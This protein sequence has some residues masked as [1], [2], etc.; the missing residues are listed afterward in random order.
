MD[1]TTQAIGERLQDLIKVIRLLKHQ[2]AADRPLVPAGLVG[3][4][5][6]IDKMSAGC[7]ARELAIHS[8]LDPSTVSRAVAG[9]VADGLVA[10]EPDPHDGRAS[11]LVVTDKG[12]AALAEAMEWY[13]SRIGQALADWTPDEIATFSRGLDR[14]THALGS[15]S[16]SPSTTSHSTTSHRTTEA[17][18]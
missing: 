3:L 4:L 15:A 11:V 12:H 10:R 6:L 14:F 8:S 5:G 16:T 2:R 7:H 13:G 9:L 18:A 17:A 1:G